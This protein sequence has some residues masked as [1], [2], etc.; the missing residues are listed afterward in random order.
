MFVK[1]QRWI[2]DSELDLGL[3]TVIKSDL[4]TV[5]IV[6]LSSGE[7]R[8]YSQ[9]TAPL[10]RASFNIG[11]NIESHEGWSIKISDVQESNGLITYQ[12]EDG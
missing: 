6:F 11:D 12:G 1:G 4:R 10:R 5:T 2:C 3:G 7:T 8:T 9:Q